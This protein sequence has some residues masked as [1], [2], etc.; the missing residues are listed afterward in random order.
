MPF[1]KFREEFP[2]KEINPNAVRK[3]GD[4]LIFPGGGIDLLVSPTSERRLNLASHS[5]E[6]LLS[7]SHLWVISASAARAI[8]K[9][10]FSENNVEDGLIKHSNLTEGRPAH[11]G[12][13]IWFLVEQDQVILNACSGRYSYSSSEETAP[14]QHRMAVEIAK[15]LK[16]KG[17]KVGVTGLD[18][19]GQIRRAPVASEVLWI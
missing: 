5:K 6:D 14:F 9:S 4:C 10:E 7:A 3:K 19:T 8:E 2:A 16:D 17:F 15:V 11:G 12:G 1:T 13:H 18:E